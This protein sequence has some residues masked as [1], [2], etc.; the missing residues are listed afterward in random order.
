MVKR[1]FVLLFSVL[2]LTGCNSSEKLL[3]KGEYDRAIEKAVKK[4]RKDPGN[5]KELYVL[6]EAYTKANTFDMDQISFLE[7]EGRSENY[8]RIYQLYGKLDRRQDRIKTLPTRLMNEFRIVN[9]DDQLIATKEQAAETAY[10]QGL[11]YL[12]LGGKE[13]ARRAFYEFEN[14]Q[15]LYPNYKDVNDLQ[16]EAS[17]LGTNQVLFVV[18]N[19]SE[20]MLPERFESE[21]RK[22]S[23]G[24]LNDHWIQY[25]VY[26]NEDVNYDYFVS[27]NINRITMSPEGLE[28]EKY[29]ETTEIQDGM[30][31]VLDERG[32][33][34]KDSL[35]NDI[36][37]PN[38]IN[39]S[40]EIE[41]RRQYKEAMVGGSL[42]YID[43]RTEQLVKSDN[44]GVTAVFDHISGSYTG[45]ER[46]LSQES[47]AITER[48]TVPFPNDE[49]MLM[50][51]ATL[52]K[53]KAKDIMYRN[54]GLLSSTY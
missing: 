6:K 15:S 17:Y 41:T 45:D 50:D 36:K 27:L 49:F 30:K 4:L 46:A 1:I 10:Q 52:L 16:R 43:L 32:N 34:M 24:E 28:R 9:Y 47:K 22:I 12:D 44:I 37:V 39:V 53:E 23:L 42:D 18:E 35:G 51:A 48:N 5:D 40:A 54:R 33:V 14:V 31:Y 13:N 21:L 38:M 3:Q 2:I 26:E 29:T 7:K 8:V 20:I 11:K 19:N 25:S